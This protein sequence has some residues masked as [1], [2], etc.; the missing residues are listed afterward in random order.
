MYFWS[1]HKAAQCWTF[2]TCH[3]QTWKN[4][5]TSLN[6]PA[7]IDTAFSSPDVATEIACHIW[8]FSSVNGQPIAMWKVLELKTKSISNQEICFKSTLCEYSYASNSL[9]LSRSESPLLDVHPPFSLLFSS[10]FNHFNLNRRDFRSGRALQ[11]ILAEICG[12]LPRRMQIL[13]PDLRR[14]KTCVARPWNLKGLR[15]IECSHHI[16]PFEKF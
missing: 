11:S 8:G 5:T 15:L 3:V 10:A 16:Q 13:A 1:Y 4:G 12:M 7:P 2:S 9:S 14:K 6:N